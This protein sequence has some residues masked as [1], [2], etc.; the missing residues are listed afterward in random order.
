MYEVD[1]IAT[2]DCDIDVGASAIAHVAAVGKLDLAV[3][4]P[5]KAG[6]VVDRSTPKATI[7]AAA[8][9][10]SGYAD[11]VVTWSAA[12]LADDNG[13]EY[14][15]TVPEYRPTG[16]VVQNTVGAFAVYNAAK[17]KVYF[18]ANIPGVGL[19]MR[20][21]LDNFIAALRWRPSG[22]SKLNVIS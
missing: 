13:L 3:L 1:L 20:S 4:V 15:G 16:A 7:D 9:D 14:I 8:A 22:Q 2:Q 6:T 17:T 19:P 5:L 10:Y 11:G 18:V 12:T 21:A